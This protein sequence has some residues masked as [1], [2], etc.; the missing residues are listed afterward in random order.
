MPNSNS[1]KPNQ[2]L[3]N[4]VYKFLNDFNDQKCLNVAF[5]MSVRPGPFSG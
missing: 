3:R 1:L 4:D 2:Q 5:F